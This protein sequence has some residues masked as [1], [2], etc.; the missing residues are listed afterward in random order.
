RTLDAREVLLETPD[1]QG[2]TTR[3]VIWMTV[4]GPYAFAFIF[5]TPLSKAAELEPYLKAV[6][7]SAQILDYPFESGLLDYNRI[8]AVE[9][10]K[11]EQIDGVLN[12]LAA[13]DSED[14]AARRDIAVRLKA[15]LPDAP[16]MILDL[17][18]DRRAEVRHAL[19]EALAGA[20]GNEYDKILYNF[21]KDR[22]LEVAEAAARSLA[23]R[24]DIIEKLRTETGEWF[25]S[26]TLLRV[27]PFLA[28]KSR[29]EIITEIFKRADFKGLAKDKYTPPAIAIVK[30][31][32]DLPPPPPPPPAPPRR[33]SAKADSA[34]PRG[35][36]RRSI[37]TGV[38]GGVPGGVPA[39]QVNEAFGALTL[40]RDI[41]ASE[42]KTPVA[43]I[44]TSGNDTLAVSALQI[45][46]ER[47]ERLPFTFLAKLLSSSSADVR[48]LAAS[49]FGLSGSVGDIPAIEQQIERISSGPGKGASEGAK[50]EDQA[51]LQA[52]RS[53]IKQ[54]RLRDQLNHA[55]DSS[56][57][58]D[59]I[60]KALAD[61][62][63][64]NWVWHEYVEPQSEGGIASP[65]GG[66]KPAADNHS[67][68]DSG[69]DRA[70][71]EGRTSVSSQPM[72]APAV[73]GLGENVFPK[74]VELYA[75]IP[76]PSA[77][78]TKLVSSLTNIQMESA[79][80]Q[81]SFVLFINAMKSSFGRSLGTHGG[82][83]AGSYAGIDLTQPIAVGRWTASGA[84]AGLGAA[85]RKAIIIRV[86]DRER[87]ERLLAAGDKSGLVGSLP[88]AMSAVAR[89][90][91]LF[92]AVLPTFADMLL[93]RD[94]RQR[95][96][97]FAYNY[98]FRTTDEIK[99]YP[100][101]VIEYRSSDLKGNIKTSSE[102]ILYLGETALVAP[103]RLSLADVLN[104]LTVPGDGLGEDSSF[105]QAKAEGGD[106]IYMSDVA[107]LFGGRAASFT[108]GTQAS[109]PVSTALK[110]KERGALRLTNGKWDSSYT[111]DIGNP[112][113]AKLFSPFDPRTH[114]AATDLLPRS[115]VMYLL[116][117][118]DFGKILPLVTMAAPEALKHL[119]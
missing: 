13:I 77:S 24:P 52:L 37:P 6:V 68:T 48:Y 66:T 10:D 61:R 7:E 87:F 67:T 51:V 21:L 26:E 109:Q 28:P 31:D 1:V 22:D 19:S 88:E 107:A 108:T 59:L 76:K 55:Q 100:V 40:L 78:V 58:H 42:F 49:H 85:R 74:N 65:V 23:H 79:R 91:G 18:E 101:T 30:A 14:P 112:V 105:K 27:W 86:T 17:A 119:S 75:A 39:H 33:S 60:E 92:P 54:I 102:Y 16:G 106:V 12:A 53:S 82:N 56:S 11:P 90:L 94:S 64:A 97:A 15:L 103:D 50:K 104:R 57:R 83:S 111:F 93:T 116:V 117:K 98:G 45:A 73:A 5:L 115:T 118:A 46:L 35:K 29:L 70:Q 114:S 34:G 43:D 81:A 32:S 4:H 8:G 2:G 63:I 110:L 44:L 84:P 69:Q 38:P 99:G 25:E 113:W 36:A 20:T 9:G 80:D 3:R 95:E 89:L 62:D 96:P 41:P 71:S 47:R 72:T